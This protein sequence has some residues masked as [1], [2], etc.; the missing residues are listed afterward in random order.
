[1]LRIPKTHKYRISESGRCGMRTLG[2]PEGIVTWRERNDLT[3]DSMDKN[4][5]STVQVRSVGHAELRSDGTNPDLNAES[6]L[7]NVSHEQASATSAMPTLVRLAGDA[8]QF[9]YEEFV[10][11]RIR[12]RYTR[13]NYQHAIDRFLQW[14]HQCG[15]ELHRI[16]PKDV[17]Q[18]LDELD[19]ALTTKKLHLSALRHFFDE[20]VTRHVVILNP[21]ATV[22]SE[23]YEVVEGKTPEIT[24]IQVRQLFES[25]DTSHV[26]GLR[27][28]AI[29]GVL[30]YTAARV[31]AVAQLKQDHLYM[32][33]DQYC[34]R[35][36]DKGGKSREI[37]VRHDLQGLLFDYLDA[38]GLRGTSGVSPLFMTS[39]GRTRQLTAHAMTAGDMC[40]MVKRRM[41]DAG[42]PSRLSPHSFRVATVTNLLEQNVSLEDV[43]RLAGH[44]DPRTTRLYDRRQRKVTRNIVERISI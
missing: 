8:A 5:I 2:I 6:V 26:V 7:A 40:R 44:A 29:I 27:D 18:Y 14:S 15:L 38:A 35:F 33:G 4:G 24:A 21:A 16:A 37:P 30:V 10:F 12:N 28:R 43:Q 17:G 11:G 42:L 1:M 13:R 39:N 25:G 31:G 19:Y 32:S 22:R 36:T 3:K 9:A 20:L 41:R 23:R 34:L